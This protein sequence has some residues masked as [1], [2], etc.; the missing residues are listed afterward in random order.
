MPLLSKPNVCGNRQEED[1]ISCL[2]GKKVSTIG[3]PAMG[4]PLV[5]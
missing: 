4:Y 5:N 2:V 3:F 1:V